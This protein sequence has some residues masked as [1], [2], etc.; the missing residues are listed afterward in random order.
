MRRCPRE[1]DELEELVRRT[2]VGI[3]AAVEV[4]ELLD[5]QGAV[6]IGLLELHAEHLPEPR[7]VASRVEAEDPDA[8]GVGR[9]EPRDHLDRRGLPGPV[10]A[11]DPEGL[12]HLDPQ[13]DPR[14]RDGVTVSLG[15]SF[16]EDRRFSRVHAST[17]GTG[18][19][20]AR[21]PEVTTPDHDFRH[22][23]GAA[24]RPRLD[25]MRRLGTEAWSG[26]AM[27]A[28]SVGVASPALFGVAE[29]LI[30]RP[31]WIAIFVLFLVSLV[32][33]T[34]NL[35]PRVL[36]LGA[37]AVA[38][39]SAWATVLSVHGMGLLL[40]LLI[41]TAAISVYVLPLWAS[42]VLVALNTAVVAITSVPTAPDLAEVVILTGFYAL[43]QLAT[44]LSTMTLLREQ[45]MRRELAEAHVELQTASVLLSES[46][47]TAERLRISRELH[48]AIG[49]QL[50]VLTLEL[51][52]ARHLDG[53]EAREHVERADGVARELLRE[54]RTT[55]GRLRTEAPD[56]ER[57]LREMTSA[58]PGLAVSVE[59]S[60][61]LRL[62]EELSAAFVR[63]AQE[64][65][66][67][68]IRHAAARELWIEIAAEGDR[69][70][71]RARDDGLGASDPVAGNGLQGLRERF[72]EL[73]GDVE[74]DGRDGFRVVAWAPS[75]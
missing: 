18:D 49:H 56:L 59:V 42:L 27:L 52:T 46:A 12:P 73:G 14:D 48:D 7:A 26:L 30:P 16:D 68:T 25:G 54:V 36:R 70:A 9:A 53:A 44:L 17:L 34:A 28:L 23:P 71:L 55:V 4:E 20:L 38:V 41:V 66:T 32:T 29:P 62:D 6:Q 74:F 64:V 11:E 15:Q 19:P 67:N 3:E 69:T 13:I 24:P 57:A 60:P 39:V 45:R 43:I 2:R 50:T 75:A 65:I 58:L 5:G 8:S 72:A 63:A 21:V 33:A 40:V 1:V 61:R 47:R 51:E 35:V 22:G 31:L 37:L 10:G